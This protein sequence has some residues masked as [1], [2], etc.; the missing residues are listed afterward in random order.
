MQPNATNILLQ[1][2]SITTLNRYL[3]IVK[4]YNICIL[5]VMNVLYYYKINVCF[6]NIVCLIQQEYIIHMDNSQFTIL[7][8]WLHII[9]SQVILENGKLCFPSP[10]NMYM[11]IIS[12]LLATHKIMSNNWPRL[13]FLCIY[14]L[15]CFIKV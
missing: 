8:V 11:E 9:F 5:S 3:R 6:Y 13:D 15:V 10:D 4:I 7:H 2:E 12:I 1:K 14:Y